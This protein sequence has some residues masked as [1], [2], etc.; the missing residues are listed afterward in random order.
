MRAARS[1]TDWESIAQYLDVGI[2]G[3]TVKLYVNGPATVQKQ[4]EILE[5]GTAEVAPAP[6][7]R[8]LEAKFTEDVRMSLG[9][10]R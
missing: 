3:T 1:N 2:M 9:G 7:L 10:Y 5:Y 6:M 8:V 4:A